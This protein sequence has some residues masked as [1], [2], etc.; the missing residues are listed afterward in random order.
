[1]PNWLNGLITYSYEPGWMHGLLDYFWLFYWWNSKKKSK[2]AGKH[3]VPVL[4]QGRISPPWQSSFKHALTSMSVRCF[5][6]MNKLY[7]DSIVKLALYTANWA[8]TLKNRDR[9]ELVYRGNLL[10]SQLIELLMLAAWLGEVW[11]ICIKQLQDIKKSYK[12]KEENIFQVKQ[13]DILVKG[14]WY[15][16][17][18]SM[19]W[20]YHIKEPLVIPAESRLIYISKNYIN[21]EKWCRFNRCLV[22][23]H[24]NE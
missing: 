3:L 19:S 2:Y 17:L 10:L 4:H 15:E 1:M 11:S 18:T 23:G 5:K 12:N 22:G 14:Q 7:T 16:I 6:S 24:N 9:Y 21:K 13:V 8:G 20:Y